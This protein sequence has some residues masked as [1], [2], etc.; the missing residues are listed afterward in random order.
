[1]VHVDGYF[2]P[3]LS[4][5]L[6]TIV[7]AASLLSMHHDGVRAKTDAS[8]SGIICPNGVAIHAHTRTIVSMS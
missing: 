5:T 4:Q 6:N 8:E 2:E 3:R 1:V 7:F